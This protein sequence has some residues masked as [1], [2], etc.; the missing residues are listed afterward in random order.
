VQT[1][2]GLSREEAEREPGIRKGPGWF[3]NRSPQIPP[4]NQTV[5]A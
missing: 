5:Q 3:V 4:D 2:L 1:R